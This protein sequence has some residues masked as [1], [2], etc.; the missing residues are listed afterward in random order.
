LLYSGRKKPS[1]TPVILRFVKNGPVL[2]HGERAQA[3]FAAQTNLGLI[4]NSLCE[5]KLGPMNRLIANSPCEF[6]LGPM[7]L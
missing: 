3:K 5:F 2:E 7:I 4:A 1:F 6:K